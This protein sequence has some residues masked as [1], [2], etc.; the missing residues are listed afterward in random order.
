MNIVPSVYIHPPHEKRFIE[1]MIYLSPPYEKRSIDSLIYLS[2]PHEMRFIDSLI[3]LS[4]P[5]EKRFIASL[6]HL[7]REE[8]AKR[9][10]ELAAKRKEKKIKPHYS[11]AG[12]EQNLGKQKDVLYSYKK[13]Q[14]N[15]IFIIL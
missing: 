10:E 15:F 8:L 14:K 1:S 2:P 13:K 11:T 6:I 7:S 3:Y 9:N 12:I 4:P 5:H